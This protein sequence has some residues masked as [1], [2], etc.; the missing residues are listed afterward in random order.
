M[1]KLLV[2]AVLAIVSAIGGAAV[3]AAAV[4]DPVIGT[5]QLNVSKSAF[6]PGPAFKSQVRTYSQSA[7]G[8]TLVI[9]TVGV[10]TTGFAPARLRRNVKIM[11]RQNGTVPSGPAETGALRDSR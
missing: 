9:K 6:K 8:I 7:Q 2:L 5:W 4:P 3:A 1:R 10:R 11:P